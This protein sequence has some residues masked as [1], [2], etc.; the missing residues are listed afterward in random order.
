LFL[1][2]VVE[3]VGYRKAHLSMFDFVQKRKLIVQI[4]MVLASLPFLFWGIES[5]RNS[6]GNDGLASVAGEKIGRAEFEQALRE[7]QE[8]M[9]ASM[10]KN[11]DP[12]ILDTLEARLSVLE[13]LIQQRLLQREATRVGLVVT[14]TQLA[15]IIRDIPAFGQDGK[16]SVK[17]YEALLRNQGMTPARFE[18]R[19][20]HELV[21]QQLS[22]AHQQSGLVTRGAVENIARLSEQQR[23]ISVTQILPETFLAQAKVDEAAIKSYYD[24]HLTEFQLPEQV[25]VEYLT[26]SLD[27]LARQAVVSDDEARKY[28]AEHGSDFGQQEERQASHILISVAANAPEADKTA[29]RNK[30]EQ[31]LAEAKQSPQNFAAL[32]KQYSQDPGSAAIG[33]DLGYF[34]RGMMVKAFEDAAYSMKPDEIRGPVQTDFGFHIIK[35]AAI[36]TGKQVKFEEVKNKIEQELKKQKAAK[37]FSEMAEGFGNLVYEQS[38]SLKPAADKYKLP[39]Q[40]SGW[41]SKKAGESAFFTS[42]KLLQAIFSEDAIKN[43][44]NTEAV[45]VMPN[46]LVAARVS[47]HRPEAMRPL[48]TVRA[49]I[50]SRI[51]RQQAVEMAVSA[52]KEKLALLQKSDTKGASELVWSAAKPVTRRQ[53]EGLD[54]AAIRAVFAADAGKLPAYAGAENPR[55]GYTLIRISRVTDA[56][57]GATDEAKYKAYAQQLKQVIAQEEFS[58]YLAEIRK[59]GDVSYRKE[60]LEKKQP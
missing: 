45:E 39:L 6:G 50:K 56:A 7:Q 8:R 43:K 21:Q 9:R 17:R 32:A 27:E 52:G 4:I 12:A 53:A 34:G 57:Q 38:D 2:F 14:D 46:T 58:A 11:Y 26:L 28:L 35:L 29:A 44:R 37:A 54:A 10:G 49:E 30:A 36:R 15:G 1:F 55:G 42:P 5:Y 19:V 24:S 40:Q 47:E 16:F 31:V 33:G 18:E 23:E 20:R 22:E 48:D 59:R 51:A 25:R 60:S 13:N 3:I 41:V